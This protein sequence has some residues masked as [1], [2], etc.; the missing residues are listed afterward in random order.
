VERLAKSLTGQLGLDPSAWPKLPARLQ[1]LAVNNVQRALG[2]ERLRCGM[3]VAWSCLI[4]LNDM[5]TCPHS[6]YTCPH[7]SR[8]TFE[9]GPA[10]GQR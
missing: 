2:L 10:V 6:Y 5:Y 8:N 7:S 1:M 4:S 3:P 9:Q